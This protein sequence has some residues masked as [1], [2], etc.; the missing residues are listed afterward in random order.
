M[1]YL[2][3]KE[4]ITVMRECGHMVAEILK[5]ISKDIRPGITTKYLNDK[6]EVLIE[7]R[8]AKPAFKGY[9]GY[10]ATICASIN[11]EVV[12][13]IP[14]DRKL[15][16]G[17]IIS[18]DLGVKFKGY[19]GDVAATFGVGEISDENKKLI[20]VTRKAAYVGIESARNSDRIGDVSC[21]IQEY[22]ESN[23]YSVVK[24][25]G[26]HGLGRNLH[27]EPH[28]PNFGIKGHGAKIQNGMVFCIEPMVNAGGSDVKV[29]EDGWTVVTCDRGLSAHFEHTIGITDNGVE[30]LTE[31]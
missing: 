17:D 4:E 27:E 19:Y 31:I 12:H 2:K 13:S 7:K 22:V 5:E 8:N 20:D 10:P 6:A 3:S 9:R 26:G 24:D 29:M 23:G 21:A 15:I 30:I 25:Y 11:E 16:N 18:I 1:I 28:V 14:S